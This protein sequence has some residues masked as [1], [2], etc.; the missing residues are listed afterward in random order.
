MEGTIKPNV[1]KSYGFLKDPFDA[2]TRSDF[3]I[4]KSWEDYLDIFRHMMQHSRGIRR[5]GSAAADLA[6]VAA[7]RYDGFYEYGLSAW[8]VA[9][10][11][12][13][14]KNAGGRI[15]DFSGGENYIFGK[16]I[17]ASNTLIH[18]EFQNLF[19]LWKNV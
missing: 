8:D 3:F 18:N 13:L 5:L 19:R 16:E 14:V 17:I 15:S 2:N 10:G 7:G 12:L 1:W 9:A 4:P 6:Y 11:L